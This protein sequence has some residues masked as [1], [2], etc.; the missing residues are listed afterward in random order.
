MQVV[1]ERCAGL[2]VHKK[3]VVACVLITHPDGNVQREIRTFSTMTVDLLLLSDWL[4]GL[5]VRVVA[6]ESTGVFWRPVFNLLEDGRT[7]VLVNPQHIKAVPG[8]KTDV[9]D[10]EWLADLLRHG[11]LK[12]S[13][14]L[15]AP[16]RELRELT[17][18]RKT[19][20]EARAREVSRVQKV[21]EG[22]NL[23]LASVATD[24]LGKSG[25][26]MLEALISGEQDPA[27]LS[28]LARGRLRSKRSELQR[29]L[30]G[31]LLAQHRILLQ[32]LLAHIDFLE[33]SLAELEAAIAR[34]LAPFG[35][36][37]ALAQTLPGIAE[38]AATA[39]IAEVG[40]DMSRFASDKHLA[41]WAGVCPG[42]KQSGGKRLSGKTTHGNPYL[43]AVLGE[44]AWAISHTKDNYLSA[45]FHRIARRRGKQKAVVAVSHSV[46]I[47]LYHMLREDKPYSD[48]GPDYFER[49][50]ATRIERYHVRQL[51][52]LGYTVTLTPAPAA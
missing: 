48:L 14:I 27:R 17:R 40:T 33:Q 30:D 22:A 5:R 44:V 7:I 15:P 49:L 52:Q 35:R 18:Y 29:A 20:V 16:L 46:L 43:R 31:R 21:L 23:K 47:I 11:L 9:K 41:S 8:R 24:V 19:L 3:T 10:A 34:C 42:N 51:E 32:H 13:F 36:A 28:E 50:E 45:Q 37:V 6:L 26:A 39:I 4:E 12:A 2:D 1:Y 38:T 25:R